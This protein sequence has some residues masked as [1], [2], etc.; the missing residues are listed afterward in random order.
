VTTVPYIFMAWCLIK[1]RDN[2]TFY[3]FVVRS[4][5]RV[6]TSSRAAMRDTGL[7]WSLPTPPPPNHTLIG[8]QSVC[9]GHTSRRI[10]CVPHWDQNYEEKL[11][12]R[13]ED[14]RGSGSEVLRIL[15]FDTRFRWVVT[16]KFWSLLIRRNGSFYPFHRPFTSIQAD[17]F[18]LYLSR[19]R[20]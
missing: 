4:S 8:W 17:K 10:C 3:L 2:F 7:L 11:S 13:H 5:W 16:F 18:R 12:L 20:F 15:I 9:L 6:S 19:N 14:V 1:H